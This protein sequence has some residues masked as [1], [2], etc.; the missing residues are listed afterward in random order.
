MTN[1]EW[2]EQVKELNKYNDDKHKDFL[3]I[4]NDTYRQTRS[5]EII[6]EELISLSNTL[7]NVVTVLENIE[8]NLDRR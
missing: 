4:V 8:T 2:L 1:L 6:A 5:L 3:Y 7:G